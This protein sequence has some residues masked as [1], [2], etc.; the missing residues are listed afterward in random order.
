[1]SYGDTHNASIFCATKGF[2][3]TDWT[4][5]QWNKYALTAARKHSKPGRKKRAKKP[6]RRH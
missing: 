1:M 2:E 6:D 4:K 3:M 5:T